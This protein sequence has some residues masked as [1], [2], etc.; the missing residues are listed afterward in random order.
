MMTESIRKLVLFVLLVSLSSFDGFSQRVDVIKAKQLYD[1]ID[2]CEL[3]FCVYNFWATW[4]APCIRELPEFDKLSSENKNVKVRLISLDAVEELNGSV[5]LFIQKREISSK[6]M[7]LDETDFNEII[8][9]I[10]D[11]WSGAIPATLIVD[12]QGKKYFYEK[13]FKAGALQKTIENLPIIEN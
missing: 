13:E 6:V 4:C 5:K 9:G 12:R 10:D 11:K 1:L 7:L 2:T 3:D 8:P